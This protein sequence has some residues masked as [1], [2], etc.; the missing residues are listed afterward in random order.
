MKRTW[1]IV[2][3]GAALGLAACGTGR[4][5]EV[6]LIQPEPVHG[7]DS[8][9]GWPFVVTHDGGAETLADFHLRI[10][11]GGELLSV[12]P[13]ADN[14]DRDALYRWRGEVRG[15]EGYWIGDVI[16]AGGQIRLVAMVRPDMEGDRIRL[17]VVHWP[18]NGRDEPV[19]PE[20]CQVWTYETERQRVA[21]ESC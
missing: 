18:T 1:M 9:I 12:R 15:G 11:E 19:G 14:P 21:Q 8:A 13:D 7:D 10:E 16:P 17:R 3:A 20:T 2:T 6:S 5:G 4:V